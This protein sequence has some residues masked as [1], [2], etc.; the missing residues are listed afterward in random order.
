MFVN[1]NGGGDWGNLQPQ[2]PALGGSCSPG[3]IPGLSPS[4][5]I[6]TVRPGV[7]QKLILVQGELCLRA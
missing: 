3:H 6:E 4:V 1:T 5:P 7:A 2:S